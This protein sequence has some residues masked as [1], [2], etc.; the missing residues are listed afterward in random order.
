MQTQK[1]PGPFVHPPL[2]YLAALLLGIGLDR[3]WPFPFA[4]GR[5]ADVAGLVAIALGVAIMPPVLRRFRRAGTS[6][7]VRKPA[8]ALITD[9]PYRFSRNPAYVALTFWYLGVALLLNSVWALLFA[10]PL[11]AMMDRWV[12]RREERHLEEQFGVQYLRYRS[13]VRRWL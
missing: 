13:S 12:I 2:M 1:G 8:S 4:A 10:L 7:D 11:L 5:W 6:F 3:R 9:G